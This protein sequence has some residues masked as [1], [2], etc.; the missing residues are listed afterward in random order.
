MFKILNLII[1]EFSQPPKGDFQDL[2][3]S[4]ENLLILSYFCLNEVV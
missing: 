3:F 4:T 2:E 1:F